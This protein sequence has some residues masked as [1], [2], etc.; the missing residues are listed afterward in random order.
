MGLDKMSRTHNDTY[1]TYSPLGT[2]HLCNICTMLGQSQRSWA[3]V[4]QML[5]IFFCLLVGLASTM[6]R[7]RIQLLPQFCHY[8][9]RQRHKHAKMI[10]CRF[11]VGS[12]SQTV[13]QQWTDIG[14]N[15]SRFTGTV[16]WSPRKWIVTALII[17]ITYFLLHYYISIWK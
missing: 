2:K 3:D 13:D 16:P 15:V 5:H 17:Y 11:N 10:R 14:V 6:S 1:N 4:V 9:Y 7:P 12:A 8:V